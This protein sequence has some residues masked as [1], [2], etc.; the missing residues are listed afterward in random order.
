M[1][2]HLLDQGS[3]NVGPATHFV[4][5]ALLQKVP[6]L[7]AALEQY[8]E[9][10]EL[11]P[12]STFFWICDFSIRQVCYLIQKAIQKSGKSECWS[13]CMLRMYVADRRRYEE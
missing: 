1:C 4:S 7:T 11:D 12:A 3:P 6:D 10:Q 9:E 2:M 8:V 13:V 5:W